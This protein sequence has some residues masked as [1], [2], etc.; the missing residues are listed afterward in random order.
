MVPDPIYARS[1]ELYAEAV[2]LMPGGVNSPVRAMGSIGRDP[3]FVAS[4]E[5]SKLCGSPS[6]P[7]SVL[8]TLLVGGGGVLRLAPGAAAVVARAPTAD[9][10]TL[11]GTAAATIPGCSSSSERS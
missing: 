8:M 7:T 4:G 11:I 5:G 9:A 10:S 3:I 6:G 1:A 2:K